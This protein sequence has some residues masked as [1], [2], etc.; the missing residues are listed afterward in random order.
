[1][2]IFLPT[3]LASFSLD[4]RRDSPRNSE[5]E[6]PVGDVGGT[7]KMPEMHDLDVGVAVTGVVLYGSVRR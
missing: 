1:M 3:A 7:L 2:S 6:G 4:T 5:Y